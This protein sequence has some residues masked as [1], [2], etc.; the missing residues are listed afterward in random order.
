MSAYKQKGASMCCMWLMVCV[1]Y[2]D[3]TLSISDPNK[4]DGTHFHFAELW[5]VI[6]VFTDVIGSL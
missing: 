6:S 2:D 3:V 1:K 5:H 4:V